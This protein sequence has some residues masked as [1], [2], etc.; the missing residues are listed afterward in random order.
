M[1]RPLRIQYPDAWYHVM[2]RG[3]RGEKVFEGK[4]DYNAFID[5]LKELVEDFNVNIAAYCLLSNHYHLLVQTP[6]ANISR[7]MRHLNG[8]YTQRFN[9]MHLCDGQLFRGRY[10]SIIVDGDSYLLE[11]LR[12]IHR[13]PL[14]AG[15]VD[16]LN[17][18]T[19]SSHKGYLSAAKKWDWLHKDFILSL[20]SKTKAESIRRY[21]R[22]VSK[23]TPEEINQIFGRRNLPTIIGRKSFVDKIK[24][25]FFAN[26]SHEEVPESRFL[27]PDVD[28]I[29]GEVCKYYKI[30]TNDLLLSR[31]G[32]FNEPRN[33]AIYLI[34]HL[35]NDTL[36]DVGKFFGIVKN[37]TISSIDRR[38][39]RE[40]IGDQKIKRNV[41]AL[42]FE[43][44][45]GQ[46]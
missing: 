28:T 46:E 2:S 30:Q 29:I 5:L 21:Q 37:S 38:L 35:R 14:E 19:W 10:K 26:K 9:R 17:K 18:Y 45:K 6:D 16:K 13:N 43:L 20:F 41:E 7:S 32:Y 15:I 23:E 36:K 22:F 39:K 12:Y 11:L 34:R 33:V 4:N 31:R 27:A 1:S 40:M 25:K 24:D 8:V 42:T 3:R 44:S